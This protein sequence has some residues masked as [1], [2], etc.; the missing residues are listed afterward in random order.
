M[1]DQNIK[2]LHL[3][4]F[5]ISTYLSEMFNVYF[6]LKTLI[7]KNTLLS[8]SFSRVL[9]YKTSLDLLNYKSQTNNKEK[10]ISL[11]THSTSN[12]KHNTIKL[13]LKYN[14]IIDILFE[15]YFGPFH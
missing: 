10:I 8:P 2:C 1:G 9:L 12:R 4:S 14:E 3:K 6:P 11:I 15:V 5:L 7:K 13:K